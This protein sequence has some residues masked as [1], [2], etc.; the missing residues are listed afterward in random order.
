MVDSF[1]L[2]YVKNSRLTKEIVE[3]QEKNS[4]WYKNKNKLLK[5]NKNKL[6]V[7]LIVGHRDAASIIWGRIFLI[8]RN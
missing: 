7:C 4:C 3:K 8:L 5:K 2:I 1:Y 6:A